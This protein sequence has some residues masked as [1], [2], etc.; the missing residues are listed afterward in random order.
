MAD[1]ITWTDITDA[2]AAKFIVAPD[3]RLSKWKAQLESEWTGLKQILG[4]ADADLR[5]TLHAKVLQY[6]QAY[7]C[8]M[9]YRDNI[10]AGRPDTPDVDL[11]TAK[12]KQWQDETARLR[13]MI[14]PDMLTQDD[15]DI[16][17]E[18]RVSGVLI[19]R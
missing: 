4:V 3:P 13:A 12:W 10:G 8:M 5:T 14:T 2:L 18:D 1:I 17:P 9:I 19:W 15:A 11:Y 6:L 7:A 16:E